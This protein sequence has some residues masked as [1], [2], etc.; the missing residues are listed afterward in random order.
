MLKNYLLV[1]LRNFWRNKTFA[2]INILGLAIGICASLVIFLVV[3]YD[4]SFDHFEKDRG[5]IYRVVEEYTSDNGV[6]SHF[7]D[8]CLP[9]GP[10]IQNEITGI[11]LTAPF[12]TWDEN[13][14]VII[15]NIAGKQ[16]AIFKDQQDQIFADARYFNLI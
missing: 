5:R 10:V 8:V 13:P 16:P 4:F 11:E 6:T 3:D 9:M 2:L 1:A 12:R 14:R 7:Q 15:P